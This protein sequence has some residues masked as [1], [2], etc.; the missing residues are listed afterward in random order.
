MY[1]YSQVL[2]TELHLPPGSVSLATSRE[3]AERSAHLQAVRATSRRPRT[4]RTLAARRL[5]AL[6]RPQRT[7]A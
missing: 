7:P 5:L 2:L 3:A 4:G 6:V 1:A